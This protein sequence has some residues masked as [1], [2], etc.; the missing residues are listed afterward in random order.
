MNIHDLPCFDNA[1]RLAR[2]ETSLE[3]IDKKLDRIL[4]HP[5]AQ[6]QNVEKLTRLSTEMRLTKW[7]GGT[8][9]AAFLASL[10]EGWI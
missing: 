7:V 9:V 8:A 5:C 2:L 6:C 10:I 4:D 3:A 1:G